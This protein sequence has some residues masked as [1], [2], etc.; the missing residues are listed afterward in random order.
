MVSKAPRQKILLKIRLSIR[1]RNSAA[2]N[3]P[4][5][6]GFLKKILIPKSPPYRDVYSLKIM[7]IRAMENITIYWLSTFCSWFLAP[8]PSLYVHVI[9]FL[10]PN[11]CSSVAKTLLKNFEMTRRLKICPDLVFNRYIIIYLGGFW[12][13]SSGKS[14]NASATALE[15]H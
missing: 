13:N 4:L 7:L 8:S 6:T 10:C 3:E 9:H 5:N 12:K 15:I 2:F 11:K 14:S 1:V